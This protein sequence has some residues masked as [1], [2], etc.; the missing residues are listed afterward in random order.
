MA[1]KDFSS[2]FKYEVILPSGLKLL[3]KVTGSVHGPASPRPDDQS[4]VGL[5]SGIVNCLRGSKVNITLG[6]DGHF[7]FAAVN[8]SRFAVQVPRIASFLPPGMASLKVYF[9]GLLERGHGRSNW[10]CHPWKAYSE[11]DGFHAYL[12]L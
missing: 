6:F 11:D 7:K 8:S 1:G 3:G 10:W 12:V 5:L 9:P 2:I 4:S